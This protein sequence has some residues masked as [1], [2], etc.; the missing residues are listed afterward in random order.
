MLCHYST[1]VT[2]LSTKGAQYP[3]WSRAVRDGYRGRAA[4]HRPHAPVPREPVASAPHGQG[5]RHRCGHDRR[6]C[7]RR[8][9]AG[10]MADVAYRELTQYF[11]RPGWVEHDPA[12]IWDRCGPPWPRSAAAWRRP[13]GAWRPSASPT[14]ARPWWPWSA[15]GR[16][17]HRAIVWQDRRTA[18][19]ARSCASRAPA[20]RARED[21]P[22]ARPLLQRHQG[23]WLLAPA[24]P[25]SQP[26]TRLS[27]G[28]VD[29]WVVWNLTGDRRAATTS[30]TLQR[31]PDPA[32]DPATL[33]GPP[34]CA[35]SSACRCS[36]AR[37]AP[38]AGRFGAA[39]RRGPG[40]PRGAR[41]RARLGRAGDQQ[42]ALFGQA[43]FVPGMA[44]VTYGTGSF[45]LVNGG[46]A[47]PAA[48][49]S[50]SAAPGT[51]A[52]RPATQAAW[53]TRSRAGLRHRRRHPVA[54]RRAR[55]HQRRRRH[56]APRGVGPRQRGRRLR[57]GPH[58]SRQPWWDPR[59]RHH[60]GPHPR[61]GRAHRAG[62]G[63]G[64]GLP[65]A[66]PARCH[67]RRLSHPLSRCAPTGAPPPW[68]SSSSSRRIRPPGR[69]AATPLEST[70][71]GAATLAGLAEGVWSS[72]DELSA[73]WGAE[74]LFE[75][76]L[77]AEAGNA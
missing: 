14:S 52:P 3:C 19:L 2:P 64:H 15:T 29:A 76:T 71:L 68:T 21:R 51:S 27:F 55:H 23:G 67:G 60:R 74:S 24:S 1:V 50:R 72:L 8:R 33:G 62:R 53:P 66:R 39:G 77:P 65:G 9:R 38:S 16:P 6:A 70:A 25:R 18:A 46:P 40:P 34:S 49:A 7:P 28:T 26:A 42:A 59:P 69:G 32:L 31:Q 44:K 73:L 20:P 63:R 47:P 4:R 57:P 10:P 41:R 5:R 12:E 54:A 17:L 37:S 30:P 48:T 11:P 56:R 36:A 43:C 75:A 13:A 61:Q 22:R 45:V 35:T 58:R